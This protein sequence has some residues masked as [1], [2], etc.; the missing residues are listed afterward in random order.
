MYDHIKKA[1]ANGD[2]MLEWDYSKGQV[3]FFAHVSKCSWTNIILQI[4]VL[5]HHLLFVSLVVFF[6]NVYNC[7]TAAHGAAGEGHVW[8]RATQSQDFELFYCLWQDRARTRTGTIIQIYSY[9]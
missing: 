1:V 5:F 3:G 9:L 8:L 7:L 6:P 4:V 2:V